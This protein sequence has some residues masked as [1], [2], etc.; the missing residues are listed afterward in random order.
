LAALYNGAYG[1]TSIYV[2]MA[3]PKKVPQTLTGIPL[4]PK[5]WWNPVWYI[6]MITLAALVIF[7]RMGRSNIF[8]IITASIYGI[9]LFIALVLIFYAGHKSG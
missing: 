4:D 6:S 7:S 3:G 8:W 5:D 9:Y 1:I 2:T